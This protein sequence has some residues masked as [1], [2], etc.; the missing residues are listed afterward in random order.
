VPTERV[1]VRTEVVEGR[2]TVSG[3]VQREQIVVDQTPS[4]RLSPT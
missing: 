2:E 4:P 1:R 3:Q